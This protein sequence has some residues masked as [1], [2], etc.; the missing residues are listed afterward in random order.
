[1]L[2]RVGLPSQPKIQAQMR[3]SYRI[4]GFFIT[5]QKLILQFLSFQPF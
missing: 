1:M 3:H 2:G 5:R 4:P